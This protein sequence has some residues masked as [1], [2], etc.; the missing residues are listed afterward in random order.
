MNKLDLIQKSRKIHKNK[1]PTTKPA[2][3]NQRNSF[4]HSK[5]TTKNSKNSAPVV[6]K[7][8]KFLIK[9]AQYVNNQFFEILQTKK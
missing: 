6:S 2:P 1:T 4:A 5:N 3:A 8:A 7:H 9:N